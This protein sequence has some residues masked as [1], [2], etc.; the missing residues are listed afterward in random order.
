MAGGD[1][2]GGS[3][4]SSLF[5]PAINVFCNLSSNLDMDRRKHTLTGL[6]ACGGQ[7]WEDKNQ[8]TTCET[9][10]TKTGEWQVSSTFKLSHYDHVAW[11]TS[12]GI[13]LMGGYTNPYNTTWILQDGT[14]M[15]GFNLVEASF[16]SCAVPDPRSESVIVTG[17]FDAAKNNGSGEW[18]RSAIRYGE[19][20]FI[21]YLPEKI[22]AFHYGC[23]GYYNNDGSLVTYS[24]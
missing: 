19:N 18:L 21:E 10:N 15:Q 13:L 4:V 7:G 1:V 17:G 5:A 12:K 16:Y 3:P 24:L 2:N 14:S 8:S 11:N 22:R 23:A 9:L 20:G 6:T